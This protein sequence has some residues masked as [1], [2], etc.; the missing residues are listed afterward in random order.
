[1]TSKITKNTNGWSFIRGTALPTVP[2]PTA[3]PIVVY[4][5]VSDTVSV[6]WTPP[7]YNGGVALSGYKI[8]I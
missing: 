6:D 7:S 8:Q 2:Y 3:A 5:G 1:M 4:N